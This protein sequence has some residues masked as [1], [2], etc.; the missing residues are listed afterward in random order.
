MESACSIQ[1][2]SFCLSNRLIRCPKGINN[3]FHFGNRSRRNVSP[4]TFSGRFYLHSLKSYGRQQPK[5]IPFRFRITCQANDDSLGNAET[6]DQGEENDESESDSLEE[7]RELLHKAIKDLEVA[8]LNSTMFEEKAQRISE[9]A[10]ALKDQAASAWHDVNKTLD[11]MRVT[12]DEESVAKEAVQKA[13]MAL[14]LA[15]ARLRVVLESLE[16]AA[17]SN[18]VPEASEK[19]DSV[20]EDREEVILAAKDDIKECQFNLASCEAQLSGLQ[21]KKDELQKEVDKLNAFAETIQISALKAEE[22]VANI[23]KLAEQAVALE[24]EATQR[25]ND[26]EIALQRAEKSLSIPQTPEETQGQLSDD[27]TTLEVKESVY[28]IYL[29]G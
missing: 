10:I 23:M 18:G 11:V 4:L 26:A 20:E 21:S 29:L 1:R 15:E 25:V 12:V 7:L 8:R 17:G 19:T 14:S 16:E 5:R 2:P 24:L 13:T 28:G 3:R 9:T 22:D 27:E 6:N